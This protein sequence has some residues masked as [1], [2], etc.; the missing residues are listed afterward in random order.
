[1]EITKSSRIIIKEIMYSLSIATTSFQGDDGITAQLLHCFQS[2]LL[3]DFSDRST[4]QYILYYFNIFLQ[5]FL[6]LH[7][8]QKRFYKTFD[9]FYKISD[10]VYNVHNFATQPIMHIKCVYNSISLQD[11][12]IIL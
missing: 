12:N 8:K 4:I 3:S 7:I 11:F 9:R 2:Y 10:I 5:N 1:M 6:L